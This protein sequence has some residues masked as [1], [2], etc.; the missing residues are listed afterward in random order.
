MSMSFLNKGN[1]IGVISCSNGLSIKNKNII[2]E[3]KLNLKSL[4][5]DMVEGDT[6]YAKEYNLFSGTGE[7]KA[8]A[9]EKLFLDK[10]IKMIF[11]ISGG[12]LANEVLE[13]LDFNLI[14]ENPKPFFG[15]SDLTVLLNAIYSQCHITTYN[16][17]LRNLIGKF[18]EEQMQ[19]FKASFIEGKEDIFNLDYEWINGSHL[20]G[21]V[22]GG[23]IRCLL[24]LAGIKYMPNFKDKILFLESFSGNSA[25]M[26]TYITQYKNLGVFNEVKGIILGEFTEMERENLK[27]DIVEILKRVIGEINI[28]ILKTRDLGHGADAKCIP[29]GK[30]LIFK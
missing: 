27:P 18:K 11:D 13:F 10:D 16:Y 9:L 5:I 17:Q 12:D 24:K 23:N 15:Y 21:I 4:D 8:R 22:V 20:E 25:K 7:E 26:V 2:E 19:N 28:P 29:I 30:Y 6:L 14:K 1:K 3:L